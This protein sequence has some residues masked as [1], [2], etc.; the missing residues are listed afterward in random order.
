MALISYEK[1]KFITMRILS[2]SVGLF[3]MKVF[4]L[5]YSYVGIWDVIS[6]KVINVE[7]ATRFLDWSVHPATSFNEIVFIVNC[8]V[9]WQA[10]NDLVFND[11]NWTN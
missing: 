10:Q 6:I 2:I 5:V 11:E 9:I 3:C 7:P 1:C 4:P 8:R